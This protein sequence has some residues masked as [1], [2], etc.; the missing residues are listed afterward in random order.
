[1]WTVARISDD[2]DGSTTIRW[3]EQFSDFASALRFTAEILDHEA[4]EIANDRIEGIKC[5]VEEL[6]EGHSW[7]GVFPIP[8]QLHDCFEDAIL[9]IEPL[10]SAE[11]III[12]EGDA[13]PSNA[14]IKLIGAIEVSPRRIKVT[15]EPS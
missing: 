12:H 10:N 4:E 5:I 11:K 7:D 3:I 14:R 6:C 15:W 1:M 2:T 8:L 13:V 9:T